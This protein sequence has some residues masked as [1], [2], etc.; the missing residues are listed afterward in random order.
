MKYHIEN[1]L[2]K[3]GTIYYTGKKLTNSGMLVSD[4]SWDRN[5]A[6]LFDNL[7]EAKRARDDWGGTSTVV[8]HI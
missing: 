5:K 3:M 2:K 8:K 6:L 1:H 4:F 7:D